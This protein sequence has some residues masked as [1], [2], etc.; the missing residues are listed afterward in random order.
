MNSRL[1]ASVT[2][3]LCLVAGA[4]ACGGNTLTL[5]ARSDITMDSTRA[6]AVAEQNVCGGVV[7][8]NDSTCVVVGYT[9][10]SGYPVVTLDRNPP[11]G[12][13]RVTVALKHNGR[14]VDVAQVPRPG[15]Q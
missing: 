1:L 7:P 8:A 9:S 2:A 10:Q 15:G 5:G 14:S 4:T 11:A 13:D 6:V 3:G 12:K